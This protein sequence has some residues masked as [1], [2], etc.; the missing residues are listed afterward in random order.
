MK[1]IEDKKTQ[2][3]AAEQE[4]KEIDN[5]KRD[6]KLGQIYQPKET[7]DDKKEQWLEDLEAHAND[8]SR[9]DSITRFAKNGEQS[10]SFLRTSKVQSSFGSDKYAY[11]QADMDYVL[12]GRASDRHKTN[13]K[14]HAHKALHEVSV[15][16]ISDKKEKSFVHFGDDNWNMV[17]HMLFGIR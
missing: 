5:K 6:R 13:T 4:L 12:Q 8:N 14:A 7:E 17:L 2:L 10:Q 9:R 11:G 1:K 15:V 16:K 3:D